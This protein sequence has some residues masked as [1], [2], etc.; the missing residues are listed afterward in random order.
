[1]ATEGENQTGASDADVVAAQAEELKKVDELVSARIDELPKAEMSAPAVARM[2][3]I[4]TS[5]ELKVLEGKLDLVS[6]RV[7]NMTIRLERILTVL[8]GLPSGADFERLD[9]QIANVRS[10][11]TKL[12]DHSGATHKAEDDEKVTKEKLD[13]FLKRQKSGTGDNAQTSGTEDGS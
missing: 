2:M 11:M 12:M 3:G 8:N 6:G 9:V 5:R 1:M 13:S 10:L 4:A 7:S